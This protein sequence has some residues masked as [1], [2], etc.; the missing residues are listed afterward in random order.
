MKP[1]TETAKPALQ[2]GLPALAREPQTHA[3]APFGSPP[4]DELAHTAYNVED[5]CLAADV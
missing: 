3:P 4:F 5:Q 2:D 1:S